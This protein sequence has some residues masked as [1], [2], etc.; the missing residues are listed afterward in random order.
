MVQLPPSFARSTPK[1]PFWGCCC[2]SFAPVVTF[3]CAKAGETGSESLMFLDCTDWYA[4][5]L[6]DLLL[7]CDDQVLSS[8]FINLSK[9]WHPIIQTWVTLTVMFLMTSFRHCHSMDSVSH[10]TLFLNMPACFHIF[11]VLKKGLTLVGLSF[12]VIQKCYFTN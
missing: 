9:S 5:S 3:I 12:T 1:I 8:G 4:V 2:F 7:Y 10:R 11:A 6:N